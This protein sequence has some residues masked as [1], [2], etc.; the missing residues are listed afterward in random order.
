[1]AGSM[2]MQVFKQAFDNFKINAKTLLERFINGKKRSKRQSTDRIEDISSNDDFKDFFQGDE[3]ITKA[4]ENA[5]ATGN[6]GKS[7]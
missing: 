1:M 6:W 2:M 7:K 5:L 3:I 4:I